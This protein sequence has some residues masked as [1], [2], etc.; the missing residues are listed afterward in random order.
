VCAREAQAPV[1]QAAE[2]QLASCALDI[3]ELAAR[4][5]RAS[6]LSGIARGLGLELAAPGR[7][8]VGSGLLSLS[9]RPGR[10]LLLLPPD[11]PG[12]QAARWQ[13]ACAGVAA[14][15]DHSSGL[16]A[17][18]L[19]GGPLR[20]VLSR[21]CRLDLDPQAFPPGRAAATIMAQVS[22]ILAQLPA[23]LMLL[24]P[25]STARHL[26]EWLASTAKPFGL[27]AGPDVTV[28]ELSESGDHLR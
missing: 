26:R 7:V 8:A 9:V 10:W 19:T 23:A 6:E 12:A 1:S 3:V 15:V 2:C 21:G 28:A 11:S 22:V 20:E 27:E 4:H 25:V 17:L 24:T 16:A 13:T 18:H 14:V 5:A